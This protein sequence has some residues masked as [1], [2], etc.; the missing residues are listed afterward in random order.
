MNDLNTITR[1]GS[2]ICMIL[3]VINGLQFLYLSTNLIRNIQSA[4]S[5][6]IIT[7][8]YIL[9]FIV[10]YLFLQFHK[11]KFWNH[12]TRRIILI[13][14][15][16]I[17]FYLIQ[18]KIYNSTGI[19]SLIGFTLILAI[20]SLDVAL[21]YFRA[22]LFLKKYAEYNSLGK[23]FQF[24]MPIA[25]IAYTYQLL[26]LNQVIGLIVFFLTTFQYYLFYHI[27]KAENIN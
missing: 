23:Y 25:A 15:A 14:I 10:L 12:K 5:L 21:I 4:P 11:I 13:I 24:V 7:I 3:L 1:L 9:K 6:F 22:G 2:K 17:V 20:A 19:L 26:Y 18:W 16:E 27:F 8:P